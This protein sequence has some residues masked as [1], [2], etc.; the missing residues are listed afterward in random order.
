MEEAREEVEKINA[1]HEKLLKEVADLKTELDRK[2]LL[3][4]QAKKARSNIK[5][6]LDEAN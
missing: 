4:E 6:H 5:S 3:S 1:D 2:T